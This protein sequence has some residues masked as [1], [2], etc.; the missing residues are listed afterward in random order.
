MFSWIIIYIEIKTS[1]I[2]EEKNWNFAHHN[3]QKEKTS[4]NRNIVI[5]EMVV[6]W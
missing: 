4:L 1:S 6:K 3:K 2:F 5:K